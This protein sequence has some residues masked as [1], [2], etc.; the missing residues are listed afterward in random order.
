[1]ILSLSEK[2][3]YFLDKFSK[4]M[5]S[6]LVDNQMACLMVVNTGIFFWLKSLFR[7][8]FPSPPAVRLL[9]KMKSKQLATDLEVSKFKKKVAPLS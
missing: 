4:K 9:V 2:E 8:A 5:T 7:G 1:M 3:G 6:N